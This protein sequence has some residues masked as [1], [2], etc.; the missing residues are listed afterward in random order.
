MAL[1]KSIQSKLLAGSAALIV[2]LAMGTTSLLAQA[3]TETYKGF[4]IFET[5]RASTSDSGQFAAIDTDL[6]YD[7]SKHVGMDIGVPVYFIRPTLAGQ[8]H[9]WN[10]QLGDPY[11]D[12]RF[13]ADNHILN[14]ATI[15]TTSVPAHATGAFSTGHVGIDWFNHFDHPINRFRP[16][17]NAGIANGIINTSQLSFSQPFRL[18]QLFRTS[19]FIAEG[20]AG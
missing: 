8:A 18:F 16:F 7:F 2:V 11:L 10:N 12:V 3:P 20:E 17:V 15:V 13:T 4:S 19:G 14:Y 1:L 9:Q 5:G 6:G